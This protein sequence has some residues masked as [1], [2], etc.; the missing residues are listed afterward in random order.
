MPTLEQ[1]VQELQGEIK[2]I[3]D[4]LSKV[5]KLGVNTDKDAT[6]LKAG[7]RLIL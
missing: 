5:A 3:K 4:G 7:K 1:Q 2:W 6:E